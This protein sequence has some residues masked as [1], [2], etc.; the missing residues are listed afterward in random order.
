MIG[1]G[2]IVA[3]IK[4][5]SWFDLFS[6]QELHYMTNRYCRYGSCISE[7]KDYVRQLK[8]NKACLKGGIDYL[9]REE[10]AE[11]YSDPRLYRFW[12]LIDSCDAE[13]KAEECTCPSMP[14]DRCVLNSAVN[15]MAPL[16]VVLFSVVIAFVNH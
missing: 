16:L 4:Q 14:T 12:G 13:L 11:Y 7:C 5:C 8:A 9:L 6:L 2:C 15:N 1:R 10:Y 3:Q